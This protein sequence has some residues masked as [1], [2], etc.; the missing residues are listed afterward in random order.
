MKSVCRLAFIVAVIA[1]PSWAVAGQSG[2]G[3][4]AAAAQAQDPVAEAYAQF[5]L[6]HRLEDDND[7]DGA[8]AAYKRAM[9]LDPKAAD[10]VSEL[11]DL[12]VRQNRAQEAQATAEQ[13]LKISPANRE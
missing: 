10:I 9:A 12:Y 5:L 13:A 1:A 8:V 4:A 2:R 3:S 6:A 11:A 7:I